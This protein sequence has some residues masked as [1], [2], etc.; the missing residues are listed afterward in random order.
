MS[1]RIERLTEDRYAVVIE[2]ETEPTRSDYD[3]MLDGSELRSRESKG[4]VRVG[5]LM[6]VKLGAKS[7][8]AVSALHIGNGVTL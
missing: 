7:F 3:M 6:R 4:S 2:N 5:G 8:A 1:T